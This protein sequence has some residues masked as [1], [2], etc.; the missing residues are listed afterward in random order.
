M[1]QAAFTTLIITMLSAVTAATADDA[2][3]EVV[4]SWYEY[5]SGLGAD[6]YDVVAYF[7]KDGA[8]GEAVRGDA[9]YAAEYDGQTWHFVNDDNRQKFVAEPSKYTPEYGGHCAYAAAHKAKAFGDPEAWTVHNGKLYFNY[10]QPVRIRWEVGINGHI[11]R[12]DVY[13][14]DIVLKKP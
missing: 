8:E 14:R 13:W 12:G 6:G 7:G 4:E 2:K 10:S 11:T 5:D 3:L 1:K 9:R